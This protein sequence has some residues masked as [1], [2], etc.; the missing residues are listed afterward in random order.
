MLG[1]N[2]SWPWQ[3]RLLGSLE[4]H[5]YDYDP[6]G[7]RNLAESSAFVDAFQAK[8]RNPADRLERNKRIPTIIDPRPLRMR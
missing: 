1:A 4:P 8:T 6:S 5:R 7:L 2:L 3:S